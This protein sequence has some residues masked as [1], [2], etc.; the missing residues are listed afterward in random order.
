MLEH[1]FNPPQE[2]L[3][4]PYTANQEAPAKLFIS[5]LLRPIVCPAIRVLRNKKVWKFCFLHLAHW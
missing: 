3:E 2:L 1:A 4:L 5:L